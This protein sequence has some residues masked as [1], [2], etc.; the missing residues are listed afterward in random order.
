MEKITLKAARINANLKAREVAGRIKVSVTT[1]SAWETFKRYPNALQ[2]K[3]LCQLYG[4]HM[5]D[6]FLPDALTTG[7]GNV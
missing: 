7:K 4:V 6:I 2:F 5:E 3:E 1:L